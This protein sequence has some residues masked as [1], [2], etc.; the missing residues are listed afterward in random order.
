VKDERDF[1]SP[2]YNLASSSLIGETTDRYTQVEQASDVLKV[3]FHSQDVHGDA[4][5]IVL[6]TLQLLFRNC[7]LNDTDRLDT[8]DRRLRQILAVMRMSTGFLGHH[9]QIE[10]LKEGIRIFNAKMPWPIEATYR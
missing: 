8:T 10:R 7:D 1:E 5:K 9:S 3:G 4:A 2:G 6:G